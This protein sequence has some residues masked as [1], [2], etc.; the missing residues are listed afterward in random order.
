M[1][2]EK[3][4]FSLIRILPKQRYDLSNHMHWMQY[5]RPGG[6]GKYNHIF[7]EKLR[8]EYAENLINHSLCDT[9]FAVVTK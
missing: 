8:T 9:L 4:G 5:R 2:L 3:C 7:S 1:L 6:F